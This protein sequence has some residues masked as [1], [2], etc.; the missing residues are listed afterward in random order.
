MR[1]PD[2][3]GDWTR[4]RFRHWVGGR[5]EG[6]S[7]ELRTLL[8]IVSGQNEII[9]QL[10]RNQEILTLGPQPLQR[11]GVGPVDDSGRLPHAPALVEESDQVEAFELALEHRLTCR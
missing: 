7:E 2:G 5:I 1:A 10:R 3:I 9:S 11:I 6:H 8:R 4:K